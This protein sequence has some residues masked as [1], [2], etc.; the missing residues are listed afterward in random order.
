MISQVLDA[1]ECLHRNNI[2]HRDI[3]PENILVTNVTHIYYYVGN[4]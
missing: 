1:V 3:K 2:A 4:R